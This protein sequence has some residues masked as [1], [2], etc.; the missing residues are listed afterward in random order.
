MKSLSRSVSHCGIR[1]PASFFKVRPRFRLAVL[2]RQN[3]PEAKVSFVEVGFSLNR[4][5]E[6]SDRALQLALRRECAAEIA[7]GFGHGGIQPNRLLEFCHSFPRGTA[8]CE[9]DAQVMVSFGVVRFRRDRL[10]EMELSL[11]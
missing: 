1:A 10:F 8:L 2:V 5:F 7:I 4:M 9:Q 11:G 6:R 3:L